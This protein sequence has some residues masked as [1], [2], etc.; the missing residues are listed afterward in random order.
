MLAMTLLDKRG[1]YLYQ[2]RPD[3]IPQGWMTDDETALWVAYYERKAAEA[4]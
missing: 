2:H 4:K 1:G 3:I